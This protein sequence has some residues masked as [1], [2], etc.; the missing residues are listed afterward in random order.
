MSAHANSMAMRANEATRL[1][2][3]RGDAPTGPALF[4]IKTVLP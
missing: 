1:D 3:S 4:D 2:E